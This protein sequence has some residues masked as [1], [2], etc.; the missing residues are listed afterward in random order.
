MSLVTRSGAF[1]AKQGFI[2]LF[3][4]D[5]FQKSNDSGQRLSVRSGRP[6]SG[7]FAILV[8]PRIE[9]S[10]ELKEVTAGYGS[11]PIRSIEA[12]TVVLH[13]LKKRQQVMRISGHGIGTTFLEFIPQPLIRQVQGNSVLTDAPKAKHIGGFLESYP[14]QCNHDGTPHAVGVVNHLMCIHK[15]LTQSF[16]SLR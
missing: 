4:L 3:F 5:P 2:A 15:P 9:C 13:P 12:D 7:V 14:F 16:Q 8:N 10:P 1:W 6:S 11:S